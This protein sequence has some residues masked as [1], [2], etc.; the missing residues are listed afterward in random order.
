M[1]CIL[2]L[3]F[4]IQ[5]SNLTAQ[6]SDIARVNKLLDVADQLKYANPDS[7]K[8]LLAQAL[9]AANKLHND[10]LLAEAHFFASMLQLIENKNEEARKSINK[11]LPVYITNKNDH[12]IARCYFQL[13]GSYLQ[14]SKLDS[15][16]KYLQITDELAARL[17]DDLLAASVF[18]NKAIIKKIKGDLR[19][20][21]DDFI[22]SIE[23]SRKAGK[24]N[25]VANMMTNIAA[26]YQNLN[27]RKSAINYLNQA[28][29][30]NKQQ[31]NKG[32]LIDNLM[33][34]ARHYIDEKDKINM[35]KSMQ[36][37][38]ALSIDLNETQYF[39]YTTLQARILADKGE[40]TGAINR[41]RPL[42]LRDETNVSLPNRTDL[43][44]ELAG[45]LLKEKQLSEAKKIALQA[46][47]LAHQADDINNKN[48]SYHLL[49]RIAKEQGAYRESLQYMDQYISSAD[50]IYQA[51]QISAVKNA[52]YK[53]ELELSLENEKKLAAEKALH[54][55]VIKNQRRWI[56][57]VSAIIALM[58]ILAYFL[59]DQKRKKTIA[60]NTLIEKN[61]EIEL[62][63]RELN[64]RVK[65]NLAFM[66]SLLEMQGRRLESLE[67][68][69]ALLASESRLRA[70]SL[71]H[72]NLVRNN[73]EKEINMR[74]YI[75]EVTHNLKEI[76]DIPG[77]TLNLKL[78]LVDQVVDAEKAMRIGLIINELFTNS[79]RHAFALVDQPF[80]H[81]SMHTQGDTL[82][83]TYQDNGPGRQAIYSE[84]KGLSTT[85]SLGTT[86]INLLIG[87]LNGQINY[88]GNLC[89][90]DLTAL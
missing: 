6:T 19:G 83:I 88:A 15:A 86:L 80:I 49:S 72:S 90:I 11:A 58:A 54:Q 7:S 16:M 4:F 36:E 84:Q 21:I 87:Q 2:L 46:L 40:T 33:T 24:M 29:E 52:E 51:A 78:D 14:E 57:G 89:K 79:I 63:N 26:I 25:N 43:R 1:K 47:Q 39:Q 67:A 9:D 65:N 59:Y 45:Y 66:T 48:S 32:S 74:A 12:K 38:T 68:K 60:N 61:N 56:V 81:I 41:L 23:K 5:L 71:V 28:I 22:I 64:H 76:F 13:A 20:A 62:L 17:N 18:G 82:K 53:G 69:D 3:V 77:K 50:T 70:L 37:L 31:K 75:D 30:I 44:I 34:L 85:T 42:L 10:T 8:L 73:Q 55:L 27:D 35:Q